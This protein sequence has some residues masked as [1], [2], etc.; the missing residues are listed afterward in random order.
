MKSRKISST[1]D[2]ICR[3]TGTPSAIIRAMVKWARTRQKIPQR[4]V[5]PGVGSARFL[6]AAGKALPAAELI[7]VEM[8]PLATRPVSELTGSLGTRLSFARRFAA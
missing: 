4:I 2:K 7:G 5:D 3:G 6:I 8:D 1:E